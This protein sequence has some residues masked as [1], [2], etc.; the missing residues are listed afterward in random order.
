[1]V[2]QGA[3]RT[4]APCELLVHCKKVNWGCMGGCIK[5]RSMCTEYSTVVIKLLKMQEIE[6]HSRLRD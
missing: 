4:Q 5:V 1:M 3:L 6:F 2:V